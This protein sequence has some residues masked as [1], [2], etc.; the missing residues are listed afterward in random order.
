MLS[1]NSRFFS[2]RRNN[3]TWMEGAKASQSKTKTNKGVAKKTSSLFD[4]LFYSD[5]HEFTFSII[6]FF[7]APIHQLLLFSLPP[8]L[9]SCCFHSFDILPRFRPEVAE[10]MGKYRAKS[11]NRVGRE[12]DIFFRAVPNVGEN[13]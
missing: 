12:G 2:N 3:N 1:S 5:T 4:S 10:V 11:T 13:P 7:S 8:P 6:F 9:S